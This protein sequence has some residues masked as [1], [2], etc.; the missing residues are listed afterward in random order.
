[1][2]TLFLLPMLALL[3]SLVS[4]SSLNGKETHA[5]RGLVVKVDAAHNT[6]LVSCDEI[7]N[8]MSAM[9]M[10]F[11]ARDPRELVSLT[12]GT[13]IDFTLVVEQDSSYIEGI[14]VRRY[15]GVEQDP[16]TARRLNLLTSLANSSTQSTVK[17]GERIPEFTLIDQ[18]RRHVSPSQFTGEVLVITFTYTHCALPNFCFRTANNLRRLQTRFANQLKQDLVL[19]SI[20]FDPAHDPP[21]VMAE[22]GKTWHAD[23][24]GWRLLTGSQSDIASVCRSFGISYFPDEGLMNHSLHTF[25]V[26]RHGNLVAD[27]EG[28]QFSAEQLGDLV[29]SVLQ[30]GSV[31]AAHA[32]TPRP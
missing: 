8:Y 31:R 21:E 13:M 27:L 4:P 6:V 25:V 26:D 14:H 2:K 15:E 29:Q 18:N 1:M 9:V 5:A 12:P 7:P 30:C 23:P 22:Y 24:D 28:N 17:I 3:G 16:L 32:S 11:P 19:M 10:D 20:T